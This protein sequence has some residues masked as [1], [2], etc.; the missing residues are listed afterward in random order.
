MFR[1]RENTLKAIAVVT[2]LGRVVKM[3]MSIKSWLCL[4]EIGRISASDYGRI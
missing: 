1:K 2:P 4:I 3:N